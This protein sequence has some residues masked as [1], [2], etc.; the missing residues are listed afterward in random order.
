MCS[1]CHGKRDIKS[2]SHNLSEE[3]CFR[4]ANTNYHFTMAL[5]NN[6]CADYISEKIYDALLQVRT[7]ERA[8]SSHF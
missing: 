8:V 4:R 1:R 5:E 2:F 6:I 7:K 3:L